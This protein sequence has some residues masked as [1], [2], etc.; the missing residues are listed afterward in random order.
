V[1]LQPIR[2]ACAV[3]GGLA[4]FLLG[5]AVAQAGDTPAAEAYRWKSVAIVGGGFVDGLVFHPTVPNLLYAR[6]DMG[7]AYRRDAASARWQP[8]LDWLPHADLNL[9]GVESV[10]LDPSDPD[11]LYLACGTYTAS[12][13]PD[14]AV[15]RSDDRGRSFQ[16]ADL[17]V[18]F[19]GNEEGRGNGDRMAVD[20]NDGRV[21]YL[22]TRLDGLW[23]SGDRAASFQRVDG[24]PAAA[25]S[26]SEAD[27]AL[28]AGRGSDGRS[29]IVFVVFDPASAAPGGASQTIYVGV[30]A[31]D[32]PNLWRSEDGGV[33]WA[34]LPGAPTAYRPT[35]ASWAADGH[36]YVSYGD[37]PGPRRMRN[38]AVWKYDSRS[39][40]W[41]DITPE[42]SD[43]ARRFGYAAV[44]V[45]ARQPQRLLAS[46]HGRAGGE[47]L[48]RSSD[49]GATWRPL[50]AAGP[51]S[52]RF[53]A[54]LAPYVSDT[55]LH[56]LF[57]VRI[58]P[59]NPDHALFTTGYGGW[60]T[61][62]LRA[63][64]EGRPTHWRVMSTGIE[65]TVALALHSPT[66][67]APLV[68]AIGDYSGFVHTRLDVPADG[69]PKPP[70]MGNTNDV[71]GAELAPEI[72]VRVGRPRVGKALG[73]SLDGGRS[74]R[75][76]AAL[77]DPGAREGS[78]AVSADGATWV[79]TPRG[80]VPHV[81]RD[82]GARWAPVTGLPPDTRVVADRVNPRRFHAVSLIG[83]SLYASDD[84]AASF[85][86]RALDLPDGPVRASLP[87]EHN[88]TERGDN[89]GGQDRLYAT[90]RREGELWLPAY[91][92][93]YHA[94]PGQ[95]FRRLPGVTEV[96]A[97][98]FGRA[99]PGSKQAT[100]YLVGMVHGRYG[101]HRSTDG[102]GQWVRI[103]DDAHQWGLIL[104]VS[105]D[106]KR[107]GRV[108][109]GTHGRGVLYGDPAR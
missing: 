102:A 29:T 108:Y 55:H 53:D 101:I 15:L 99:A 42:R 86:E 50:F 62:D 4:M 25:W 66:R 76:P 57:D 82:H 14:G 58:N 28:P 5:G 34:P 26:R 56:W 10:A 43:G 37:E 12:G 80:L 33:S 3:V 17:P 78:I 89:R 39:Q 24:F 38:G 72:I 47:E 54:K 32:R 96:H 74:W 31:M 6:T 2:R 107:F 1:N 98:G 52:A 64:D 7:G 87:G 105:G 41:T 92:G 18:K 97:F 27:G 21:L 93:L 35:R 20:P 59:A 8:L 71:T 100:L 73:Y 22:G 48:F 49:G 16:R 91:H 69:N 68:S 67:G 70:F 44:A 109:V 81:S 19:G 13:V 88:R 11:R 83:D 104:Q 94:A 84:A 9:M 75:E 51:A 85:T 60:E 23:R 45:D 106:P 90:P 95:S 36:L 46:T 65:E 30:S 103:N 61:H 79:W 40:R 77:P 63:A